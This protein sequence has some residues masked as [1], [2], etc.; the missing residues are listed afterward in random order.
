MGHLGIVVSGLPGFS[1]PSRLGDCAAELAPSSPLLRSGALKPGVTG[2]NE[3]ALMTHESERP[4]TGQEKRRLWMQAAVDWL[5][6]ALVGE[7]ID[8]VLTL[9]LG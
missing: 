4:T 7:I 2:R 8:R 9:W 1:F 3:V 6:P 5:G